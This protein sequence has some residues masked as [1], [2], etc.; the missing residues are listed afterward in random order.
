MIETLRFERAARS[1]RVR[2]PLIGTLARAY[3]GIGRFAKGCAGRGGEQIVNRAGAALDGGL[4]VVGRGAP[5][6]GEPTGAMY[7]SARVSLTSKGPY[8][9][10]GGTVQPRR[11]S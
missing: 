6:L 4:E 10:L 9:G 7:R 2:S 3:S 8:A 11:A 1:E 5:T